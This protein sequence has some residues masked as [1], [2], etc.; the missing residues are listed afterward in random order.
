MPT[1]KDKAMIEKVT[2]LIAAQQDCF[3]K[4]TV[5]QSELQSILGGGVALGQRIKDIQHTFGD[6][7][8]KRYGQPYVWNYAK[9]VP[10]IKRLLRTLPAD[11]IQKRV[12][13]YLR[14]NEPF[15]TTNRHAFGLFVTSINTHTPASVKEDFAVESDVAA[16]RER[17]RRLTG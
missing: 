10:N 3:E 12:L 14:N 2:K 13:V 1:D 8:A 16:T 9:D 11:E 17:M 5:I 6:E 7:W 4:L 15:Y